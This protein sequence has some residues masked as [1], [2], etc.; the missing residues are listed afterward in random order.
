[1]VAPV[2]KPILFSAPMVRALLAGTKT[3]TRRILNDVPPPPSMDAIHSRHVALHPA[4][5]FDSYC[6]ERKTALNPRGKSQV[7]CWWTR[8][9]RAGDSIQV[10]WKPGD[11]LWVREAWRTESSAYDDLKPA[12]MDADYTVLYDADADWKLN[13]STGRSRVSI[14]MP[15]WASRLT[16]LV[17]DVRV[18]RLHDIS[19]DD[20]KAEGCS[21]GGWVDEND[22]GSSSY[23]EGYARLWNTINGPGAWEANPWIVALTFKVIRGNIDE[24]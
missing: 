8:D 17:T 1:M 14:H 3:Q 9:D 19:E 22:V 18:E 15:R 5:Y 20:A 11:R 24:V 16:L 13:K 7:W 23:V 10:R 6:S 2:D 12:D 21:A 4:P